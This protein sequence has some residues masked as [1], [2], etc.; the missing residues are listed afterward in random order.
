MHGGRACSLLR[1][2]LIPGDAAAVV[3]WSAQLCKHVPGTE[4]VHKPEHC[5]V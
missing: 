4:P 5:L 1:T 3:L 2:I